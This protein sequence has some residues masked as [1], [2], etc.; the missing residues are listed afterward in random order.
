MTRRVGINLMWL[1]PGVVGGSEEATLAAVRAAVGPASDAGIELV[2]F[3]T[4]ALFDTHPDLRSIEHRVLPGGGNRVR[5]V[6]TENT[7][8]ARATSGLDLVHHAGGVVPH[9]GVPATLA[10]H[11]TQPLDLPENFSWAK[12]HWLGVMI[13][14]SVA[15][16]VRVTVPSEFVRRRLVAATGVDA[17]KVVV[18]PWSAPTIAPVPAEE[19]A[20]AAARHGIRAPYVVYPAITYAHKNHGVLL[21]AMANVQ[22]GGPV[23]LVLTGRPGPLDADVDARASRPDLLGRVHR[24]GRLPRAE[25]EALVQGATVVAVPSTYEGFGLPALEALAAG[26]PAVVADAGS[27]PEVVG[28][29]AVRVAPDDVAGWAA[30]LRSVIDDD[31]LRS[32]LVT[33]GER[34]AASWTSGRTAVGLVGVWND[35][36]RSIP[37]VSSHRPARPA[38][39]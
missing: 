18:V 7:A 31:D 23:D 28:D 14:R 4:P 29:A 11:D 20:A 34:V 12:R 10:I 9:G 6:L 17:A 38:A 21:D 1:V 35:A 25:L 24:L 2:L 3:G 16:A 5:R 30:A 33:D 13:G 32:R 36:L 8:L 22:A 39:P 37:V 19:R 27:L 15:R 26:V